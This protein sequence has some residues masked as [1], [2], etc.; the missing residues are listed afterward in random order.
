MASLAGFA[1]S[2][3]LG[4][5]GKQF[6]RSYPQRANVCSVPEQIA[7]RLFCIS[8]LHRLLELPIADQARCRR[9]LYYG[10]SAFGPRNGS[11]GVCRSPGKASL[12]LSWRNTLR[13]LTAAYAGGSGRRSN[14]RRHHERR[15]D[16][17]GDAFVGT[18]DFRIKIAILPSVKTAELGLE[19]LRMAPLRLVIALASKWRGTESARS[20]LRNRLRSAWC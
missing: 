18:S 6:R 11:A 4:D 15:K 20:R 19:R 1:R 13:P 8:E 2:D 5:T 16:W 12:D 10:R 17:V 7:A 14:S 9:H 3:E